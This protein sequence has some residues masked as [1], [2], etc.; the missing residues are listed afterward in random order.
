MNEEGKELGTI[1]FN[2]SE[3]G[4]SGID[5]IIFEPSQEEVMKDMEDI[6]EMQFSISISIRRPMRDVT[7]PKPLKIEG[8]K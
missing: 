3:I 2:G 6:K 1:T 4:Q 5:D 7:P 8:P